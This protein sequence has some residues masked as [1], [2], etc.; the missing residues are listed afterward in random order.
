MPQEEV[1]ILGQSTEVT[2]SRDPLPLLPKTYQPAKQGADS[3]GFWKTGKDCIVN[4]VKTVYSISFWHPPPLS[5][6]PTV[7]SGLTNP[8]KNSLEH[9]VPEPSE[10]RCPRNPT[11]PDVSGFL[12]QIL[13]G[14][15]VR[16]LLETSNRSQPP[17]QLC[18]NSKFGH[19]TESSVIS[20]ERLLGIQPGSEGHLPPDPNPPRK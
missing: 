13:S 3:L 15:Q 6:I 19:T 2:F 18:Q 4:V 10:E 1:T 20:Q 8:V 9:R 16:Q 12:F 7:W 17:Q 5:R 11:R 14:H